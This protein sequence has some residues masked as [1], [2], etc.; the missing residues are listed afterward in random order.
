MKTIILF[1]FLFIS[2]SKMNAQKRCTKFIYDI[3]KDTLLLN[4]CAEIDTL[5]IRSYSGIVPTFRKGLYTD[6][7]LFSFEIGYSSLST[8]LSNMKY[9]KCNSVFYSGFEKSGN[10]FITAN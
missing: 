10:L 9:L 1:C 3:N 8:L 7:E 6:V 2:F 4:N 5:I